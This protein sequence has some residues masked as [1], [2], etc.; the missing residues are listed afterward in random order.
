MGKGGEPPS[1]LADPVVRRELQRLASDPAATASRISL[2]E[3]V[4]E[5]LARVGRVL[6]VMGYIVGP[7]RV[8]GV[9]PFRFGDDTAVGVATVAQT[10]GELAHGAVALL[11][12]G[13]RYAAAALLRQLVEVEYLA[14]A[15]EAQD[16]SA[17]E[18]LRAVDRKERLNFWAP[19][20]L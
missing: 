19:A 18:W 4:G 5:A 17:G 10:G 3:I 14:H 1:E 7:D 13:N 20:K 11:R 15:F 12:A 6:W 9:S 16:D 2:C 8:S